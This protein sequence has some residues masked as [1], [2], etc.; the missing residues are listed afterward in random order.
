[1]LAM[2]LDAVYCDLNNKKVVAL[3]SKSPFLPLF[4]LCD[5]LQKGQT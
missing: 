5:A 2:M 4:S 1:M 3:K